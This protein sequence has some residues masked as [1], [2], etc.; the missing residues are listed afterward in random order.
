[1]GC[2]RPP[3]TVCDM[4][5]CWLT[6]LLL[7]LVGLGSQP[8][9]GGV[10]FAPTPG[11]TWQIQFSGTIDTDVDGVE[12][13]DLDM[14]ETDAT[15]VAGIHGRGDKAICYVNAGAWERWRDDKNAFPKRVLGKPLDGWPGERWLDIRK[16][17]RL[18]PIMEARMD[19]C[20]EKGFDGIEF[21]NVDGYQNSSGFPLKKSHQI[22]YNEML[23]SS[24]KA[25]GLAPGLKNALGIVDQ[26]VDDYAFAIN[27]QCLQYNECDRLVPFI[28]ANKAVFHIEYKR[29][30]RGDLRR[31]Q[32]PR[33]F[34]HAAEAPGSRC[35]PR[36]MCGMST[37]C[38]TNRSRRS[39]TAS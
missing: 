29:D 30:D 7:A 35:I 8:A 31:Y 5:R 4:R 18:R 17:N 21:D 27:E 28:E 33:R 19:R 1:M 34:Q 39:S 36:G 14:E 15:V 38:L 9:R 3:D 16:I 23:A 26:L 24:A 12:V 32:T 13:Y 11:T 20:A 6:A 25:R 2:V 22:A 10:D 37:E